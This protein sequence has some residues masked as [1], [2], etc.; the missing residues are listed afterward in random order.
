M[1][2]RKE[3]KGRKKRRKGRGRRRERERG[4]EVEGEC[5]EGGRVRKRE[6]KDRKVMIKI[7]NPLP[8]FSRAADGIPSPDN[9]DHDSINFH[10]SPDLR[11]G[12]WKHAVISLFWERPRGFHFVDHF[13]ITL[14]PNSFTCGRR[15][16]SFSVPRVGLSLSL[17][18]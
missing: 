1:E 14:H 16:I 18:L 3:I 17:S 5:R 11:F 15:Q 13:V 10:L 4:R 12:F 9:P 7:F 6:S 2:V 8:L